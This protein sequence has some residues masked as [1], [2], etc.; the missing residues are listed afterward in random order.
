MGRAKRGEQMKE[1][2]CVVVAKEGYEIEGEAA[3]EIWLMGAYQE[4]AGGS[5][6]GDK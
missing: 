3:V 2:G 6:E 1:E 5:E 4:I